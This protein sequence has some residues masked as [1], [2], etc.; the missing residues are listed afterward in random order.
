ME[1]ALALLDE[2]GGRAKPLAGGQS[3]IPA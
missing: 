2:H 1:E 3:L